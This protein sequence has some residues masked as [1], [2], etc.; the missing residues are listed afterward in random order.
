VRWVNRNEGPFWPGDLALPGDT[1]RVIVDASD[2]ARG[3]LV[4]DLYRVHGELAKTSNIS[5]HGPSSA[6]YAIMGSWPY[7]FTGSCWRIG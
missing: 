4:A 6:G 5:A 7:P 3:R 2:T 1:I